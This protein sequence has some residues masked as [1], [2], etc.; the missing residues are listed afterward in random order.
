[1]TIAE[2]GNKMFPFYYLSI[3]GNQEKLGDKVE[4]LDDIK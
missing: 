4:K 2:E 3:N 1:M